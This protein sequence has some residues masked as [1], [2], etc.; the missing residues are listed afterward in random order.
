MTQRAPLDDPS[1]RDATEVARVLGA[2]LERGLDGVEAS[3]RLASAGPNELRSAPPI[4]AWRRIVAQLRDPLVYLLLGAVVVS[5]AAWVFE[6]AHGLP[7]E[8]LVVFVIVIANAALGYA[9]EARAE[10][11]VAALQRMTATLASVLRNGEQRRIPASE[12]VAGDVLI[13]A[14]GDAVAADAR[15][16]R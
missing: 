6:G 12:V 14:E 11:A 4:P 16:I 3:R 15:A 1:T 5:L 7:F 9:E 13:L 2:D 10:Q 8:A